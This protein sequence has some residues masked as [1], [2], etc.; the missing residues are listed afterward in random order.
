MT[1][2]QQYF[3]TDPSRSVDFQKQETDPEPEIR[4]EVTV[5]METMRKVEFTSSKG[6]GEQQASSSNDVSS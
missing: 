4:S 5:A 6:T 2:C 3:V 1:K